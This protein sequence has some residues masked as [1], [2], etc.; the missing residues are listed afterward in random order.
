[1]SISKETI[2]KVNHQDE[3]YTVAIYNEKKGWYD[4]NPLYKLLNPKIEVI[5]MLDEFPYG[6]IKNIRDLRFFI[7]D[8]D[9]DNDK[10]YLKFILN[11]IDNVD[12]DDLIFLDES[13]FEIANQFGYEI[14]FIQ[15]AYPENRLYIGYDERYSFIC[16]NEIINPGKS[17]TIN[18][19]QFEYVFNIDN[20]G[21]LNLESEDI[22]HHYFN[23]TMDDEFYNKGILFKVK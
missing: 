10:S 5:S 4:I 3:S 16:Y 13:V 23:V 7:E 11:Q 17:I 1:M 22:E 2:F 21:N 18:H 20:E 8:F 15:K 19:N 12:I 6:K 14:A 9:K